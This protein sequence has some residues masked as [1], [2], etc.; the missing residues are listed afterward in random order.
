MACEKGVKQDSEG[1]G[2]SQLEGWAA[3]VGMRDGGIGGLSG[4]LGMCFMSS[5][6]LSGDAE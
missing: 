2:L 1:F 3:I 4:V 6:C 5:G